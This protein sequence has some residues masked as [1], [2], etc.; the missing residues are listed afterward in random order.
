M[1]EVDNMEYIWEL[2]PYCLLVDW[3]GCETVVK[4]K[5]KTKMPQRA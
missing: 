4:E 5:E 3:M 2:E 1:A